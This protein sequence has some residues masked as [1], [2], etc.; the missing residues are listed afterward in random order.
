VWPKAYQS[1][2]EK[3]KLSE[4]LGQLATHDESEPIF[5]VNVRNAGYIVYGTVV[6]AWLGVLVCGVVLS[7]SHVK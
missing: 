4:E 5:A 7:V 1:R 3:L 2:N 6:L